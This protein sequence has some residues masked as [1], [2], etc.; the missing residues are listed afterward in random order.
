MTVEQL[1]ALSTAV[2]ALT[3]VISIALNVFLVFEQ[4]ANRSVAQVEAYP[5]LHGPNGVFLS[6]RL[7]N[8][9]PANARDVEL[10]YRLRDPAGEVVGERR[11]GQAV[12]AVGQHKTFLPD[13]ALVGASSRKFMND[14]A[15]GDL[16][17]EAEW[18]WRDGRRRP[19]LGLPRATHR[20]HFEAA[21]EDLRRDLYGGWSLNERTIDESLDAVADELLE[22]RKLATRES[23]RLHTHR[24]QERRDREPEITG[25]AS[26]IEADAGRRRSGGP[27]SRLSDAYQRLIRR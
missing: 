8:Y 18:S 17:L 15:E 7:E 25:I 10:V 22:L 1:N 9:G 27:L 12:L 2:V 3:A 24:Q 26:A 20:R 5:A 23:G 16:R 14:L 21:A 6:V 11:H 13:A 4:R 19:R